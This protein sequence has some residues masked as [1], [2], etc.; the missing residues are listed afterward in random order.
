M[1]LPVFTASL[2]ALAL[3]T[4][5]HA[6]DIHVPN[7]DPDALAAAMRLA[8]AQPGSHRITLAPGGLYTLDAAPG[9]HTL[10]VVTGTLVIDGQGAEIRRYGKGPLTLVEV[11]EGA[12]LTLIDVTLAEGNH[13][14]L[15]NLGHVDLQS[16]RIVD[17][18]GEGMRG[19]VVNHGSLRVEDSLFAWNSV[20]GAGRDAG[21]VVNHGEMHLL[22]SRIEGN[23]VSRRWPSLAIAAAVLNHGR[24][25]IEDSDFVDNA[26]D[27]D[28]GGLATHGVLNLDSGRVDGEIAPGLVEQERPPLAAR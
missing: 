5:S 17:S 10:P 27:D 21:T 4:P 1:R 19:V 7:R 2:L 6:S 18:S 11:A 13:G 12:R 20:A 26:V 22:R 28:F 3:A 8:N 23:R 16:V 9:G 15:R 14:A 24:V 25:S